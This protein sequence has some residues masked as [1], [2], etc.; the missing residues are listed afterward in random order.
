MKKVIGFTII[1]LFLGMGSCKKK[2]T[3]PDAC[4]TNWAVTVSTKAT[5]F[6]NAAIAYG[7]NATLANCNAYKTATQAYISALEPLNNCTLWAAQ[8]KTAF[9]TAIN[10]AKA[11]L[12]DTNCQ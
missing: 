1:I 8:D 10:E 6:Y 11:E 5:A 9:Q 12:A 4:G 2:N 3:E 7:T